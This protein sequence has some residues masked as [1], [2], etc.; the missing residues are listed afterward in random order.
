[1]I[2]KISANGQLNQPPLQQQSQP[3]E[4]ALAS[5]SAQLTRLTIEHTLITHPELHTP[6]EVQAHL[7]ITSSDGFSTLIMKAGDQFLAFIRRDDFKTDFKKIKQALGIKNVRMATPEEFID[8]TGMPPGA[9]RAYNPNLPTYIDPK[10]FEKEYLMGGTG[11][12]TCSIKY[13]TAD[14][15]KIPDSQI[16]DIS[17]SD[18]Q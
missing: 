8:V 6:P 9:A 3:A 18:Q 1:M 16:L 13:K 4:Q 10:I 17:K 5:Y 11:S 7:G 14:L 12:F 2:E 15:R